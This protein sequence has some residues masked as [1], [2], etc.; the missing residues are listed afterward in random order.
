MAKQHTESAFEATIEAHLLA[1]DW[2]R[3]EPSSYRV[4]LGFDSHEL[5]AFIQATQSENWERLIGLRG[6]QDKAQQMF[7]KRVAEEIDRR[8]TIHVLRK[9]VEDMGI[10]FDLAYFAPAHRITQ[11]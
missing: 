3:G 9:G 6:G 7:N 1:N 5:L 4:D 11:Q 8:G 2:L 10:K